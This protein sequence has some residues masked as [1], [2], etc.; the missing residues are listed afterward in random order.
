[1]IIVDGALV[2]WLRHVAEVDST[3]LH[4]ACH[5]W[6]E[7]LGVEQVHL[8]EV[9]HLLREIL[10]IDHLLFSHLRI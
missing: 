3:I 2:G 1:M 9:Y 10:L 7:L 5:A 4:K 6:V 8:V